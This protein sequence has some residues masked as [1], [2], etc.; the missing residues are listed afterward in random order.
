MGHLAFAVLMCIRQARAGRKFMLEHP[1]TARSW[2]TVLMNRLLLETGTGR[3]N[4][5]L[6][7]F[8]MRSKDALGEGH[9]RPRLGEALS[10]RI[11]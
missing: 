10:Q 6:C 5:D 11:L 9:A 1:A 2:Q 7:R 8:G 4:F 3:V